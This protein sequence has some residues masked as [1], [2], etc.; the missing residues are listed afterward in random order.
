MKNEFEE[1]I[2]NCPAEKSCVFY[3]N[4]ETCKIGKEPYNNCKKYQKYV[5]IAEQTIEKHFH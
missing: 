2:R 5:D 1:K 4:S 3:L